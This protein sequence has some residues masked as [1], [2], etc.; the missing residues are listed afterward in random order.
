M[1][2]KKMANISAAATLILGALFTFA[3][4]GLLAWLT[5]HLLLV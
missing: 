4:V 5:L 3:W 2:I 1:K